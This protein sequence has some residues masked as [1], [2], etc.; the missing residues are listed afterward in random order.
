MTS[1]QRDLVDEWG[2]DSRLVDSFEAML[3]LVW[4]YLLLPTPTPLQL[5]IARYAASGPKRRMIQAFRGIGKSWICATLAVWFLYREP[6]ER[7]LVV[8]ASED[9]A[10]AFTTFVKR[11]IDE[12]PELSFLRAAKG[13]VRAFSSWMWRLRATT[14][15][16]P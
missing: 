14:R 6:N 4:D 2:R 10:A 11:L 13:A 12:I 1:P 5:D 16:L 15:A 3:C 8:S 9:R 7:I